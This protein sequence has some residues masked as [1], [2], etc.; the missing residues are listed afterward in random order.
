MASGH[1]TRSG[2]RARTAS[3]HAT[4]SGERAR[5]ASD[6]ATGSAERACTTSDYGTGSAARA[7][8]TSDSATRSPSERARLR[9]PQ[10]GPPSARTRSRLHRRKQCVRLRSAGRRGRAISWILSFNRP[11]NRRP[12]RTFA[13]DRQPAPARPGHRLIPVDPAEMLGVRP[14]RA[15]RRA[16]PTRASRHRTLL[17]L[18]SAALPAQSVAAQGCLQAAVE[19]QTEGML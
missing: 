18:A 11:G 5:M 3:D 12:A 8:P 16:R 1:A 7:R 9:T 6:S 19:A 2:E 4:G 13:P 15:A 17:R 14:L 10:P